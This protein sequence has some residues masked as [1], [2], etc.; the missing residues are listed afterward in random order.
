[1]RDQLCLSRTHCRAVDKR[2]ACCNVEITDRVDSAPWLLFTPL[3]RSPSYPAPVSGSH[4]GS[5]ASLSPMNQVG[6]GPHTGGPDRVGVDGGARA[7]IGE[8]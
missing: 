8:C 2:R 7:G 5:A 4:I 6:C 1:M 3:A